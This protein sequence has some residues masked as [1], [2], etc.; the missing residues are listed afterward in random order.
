MMNR[1]II[2]SP[3]FAE[4]ASL[5]NIISS[6]HFLAKGKTFATKREAIETLAEDLWQQYNYLVR[7]NNKYHDKYPDIHPYKEESNVDGPVNSFIN[8]IEEMPG[9]VT[10]DG[11]A[12]EELDS[13]YQLSFSPYWTEYAMEDVAKGDF[14]FISESAEEIFCIALSKKYPDIFNDF[15]DYLMKRYEELVR[16]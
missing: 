12:D 3:G 16:D 9:R 2:W 8:F 5:G 13:D 10:D 4:N 6:T 1:V 14:I 15:P 7:E 11:V